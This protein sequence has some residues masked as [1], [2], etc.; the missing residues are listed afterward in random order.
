MISNNAKTL[1]SALFS[2]SIAVAAMITP[3]VIAQEAENTR[4]SPQGRQIAREI[5]NEFGERLFEVRIYDPEPSVD[6]FSN[7]T[8][9]YPLTLSF[10]PPFGAVAFVPGYRGTQET[11][12]WW[13]PMLASMGIAVMI[14]DTNQPDDSLEARKQALVAAIEFLQNENSNS[15]SPIQGKIDTSK[16]AIMGHSLGGGAA[17]HAAIALGD[18][19][20]AVIPLSPYCCELG[21]SFEADFGSLTVPTLIFVSAEDTIAPPDQHAKLLYDTIPDS[22]HKAYVEFATGDHMIVT[23]AGPDLAT[24]GR[25]TFAWLQMHFNEDPRY[26][27]PFSGELD[28]EYAAKFSRF[29][30]NR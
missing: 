19:I 2:I 7:A 10:A 1:G 21:Q 25:Y 13:G 28:D 24:L 15:D 27:E 3:A 16:L 14:L 20:K 29:E 9:F 23:N 22:T 11:Y 8:I 12:N 18:S 4:Y 26:M 30:S 17:L 6:E 5:G